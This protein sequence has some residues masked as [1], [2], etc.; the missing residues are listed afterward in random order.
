MTSKTTLIQ[1]TVTTNYR[2]TKKRAKSSTKQKKPVSFLSERATVWLW[3]VAVSLMALGLI[4]VIL[5]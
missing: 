2:P 4:R 1:D 3:G 5:M